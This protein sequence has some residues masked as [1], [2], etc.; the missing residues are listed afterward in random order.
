[1]KNS[2]GKKPQSMKT[3]AQRV[4]KRLRQDRPMTTISIRIPEDV[5]DDLKDIAPAL[6]YS[7]YQP[8]IRAYIGR[9]LRKDLEKLDRSPGH[10]LAESLRKRGMSDSVIAEVIAEAKVG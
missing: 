6:G 9:G 10:A 1:M 4:W 2:G 7:G 3:E 8:L 5:I